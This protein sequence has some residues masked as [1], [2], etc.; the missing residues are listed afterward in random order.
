MNHHIEYS[1]NIVRIG[2]PGEYQ[3]FSLQEARQILDVLLKITSF[4]A[5]ELE[6]LQY[7]LKKTLSCDPRMSSLSTE[8]EQLVRKWI[9]KI[10]RLGCYARDLWWVDIDIGEGYVCWKYP[11]IRIEYF[12]YYD[13]SPYKRTSLD[14]IIL[15]SLDLKN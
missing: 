9:G 3:I 12:H 4:S 13:E 11:E 1:D 7:K 2:P 5:A 15:S 10:E 8:Y 6:P 14:S